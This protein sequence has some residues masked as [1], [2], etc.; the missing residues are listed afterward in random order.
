[1]ENIEVTEV[2]IE[3]KFELDL[4]TQEIEIKEKNSEKELNWE[5]KTGLAGDK[6][7]GA[8]ET[9]IFMSDR[10][11]PITKLRNLIHPDVPLRIIH[12]NL[13]RLQNEYEESHHGIRLQEVA[14]GYQFKTK[15]SFSQYVRGLFKVSSFTL[16][17]TALE[18]MAI[19]AYRQPVSKTNIEKIRGVDSSHIVRTLMDRRLVKIVGRSEEMGRPVIYGTTQEFLEV[20]NLSSIDELPPEYELQNLAS[21]N[22]VGDISDMKSLVE[23]GAEEILEHDDMDELDELQKNIKSISSD[24]LFTK[25]LRSEEK[26]KKTLDKQRPLEEQVVDEEVKVEVQEVKTAFDILEE[27]VEKKAISDE[28]INA[29]SSELL[30]SVAE[31][32]VVRL[33]EGWKTGVLINPPIVEN[34]DQ[35]EVE[36]EALEDLLMCDED[37]L[38]KDIDDSF[39]RLTKT[40]DNLEKQGQEL[41]DK[42]ENIVEKAQ[43]LDLD[44]SFLNKKDDLDIDLDN[45]N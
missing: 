5:E 28:N 4:E 18:V 43:N 17:P 22:E 44:L 15:A 12:D 6:I 34:E 31:P 41:E 30:T 10:P 13:T 2:E 32:N 35:E 25:T 29:I 23:S 9:L 8:L 20:F 33:D 42:S 36:T 14:E 3:T 24:T 45:L 27:F 1:M 39:D 40:F 38:M 26:R 37:D 19:I 7:C 16:T 21:H 11:A